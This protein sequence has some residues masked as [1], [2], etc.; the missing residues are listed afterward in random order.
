MQPNAPIT[1]ESFNRQS[2]AIRGLKIVSLI[3]LCILII[4]IIV[5]IVYRV[6]HINK[7]ESVI[8]TEKG[9]ETQYPAIN[10]AP[11]PVP[12]LTKDNNEYAK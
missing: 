3:L 8:S 5:L 9:Y 1:I 6:I 12:K 4:A 2:K 11:M 10:T 7:Y